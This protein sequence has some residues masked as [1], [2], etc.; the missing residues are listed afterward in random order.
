[1]T[2]PQTNLAATPPLG[3]NSWN[4]F[5]VKVNE[6]LVREVADVMV[7]SGLRDCGYE[8]LV[9]DDCWSV[10]DHR[11]GNGDLIP[12]PERFPNGIKALADTVHSK[13]LKFGI[14]SDAADKTCAGYPGSFGFEEQDARLWASW[15]VDFLKYDY[16]HAPSDQV[17]AIERYTRMGDALRGC[18]REILYSICEWGGRSPYLWARQAGGQM[19]RVTGDVVDSWTNVLH[20][21]WWGLGIDSAIDIAVNLHAYAGPGGWN[22]LDMLVVGLGGQGQVP[23]TGANLLEY[24]TQVSMWS[25]L[26]SPLMIGCDIRT[27]NADIARLLMNQEVLMV[28]QDPLGK[29]A[30]RIK[31]EGDLELWRKPMADGSLVMAMLN[32]GSSGER[33]SFT[34]GEIGLLDSHKGVIR[35]LWRQE[36]I[37]DFWREFNEVILP[38]STTLIKITSS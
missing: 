10:K 37:S 21:T 13:G 33:I 23:G 38:H 15:G 9:I 16:C 5:G 22:D 35:D 26:C 28:N 17:T 27:M 7:S 2:N 8:Y 24:Q 19:W 36:D 18:G 32:R 30:E 14:Y 29:Q 12:D 20:G 25:I 34:A 11:D 4:T 3:W 31:K 1:M 6:S